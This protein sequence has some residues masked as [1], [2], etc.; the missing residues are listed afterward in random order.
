LEEVEPRLTYFICTLPRSGSWL[1]S[2]ALERTGLAGLPREFF[3]PSRSATWQAS[4]PADYVRRI[5]RTGSTPNGVFGVKFHWYQFQYACGMFQE[6]PLCSGMLPPQAIAS[7]FGEVR[8]IWLTRRDKVRQAISYYR[9]S[10]TDEW[11]IVKGVRGQTRSPRPKPP[12]FDAAA[13]AGLERSVIAHDTEWQKYFE[14]SGIQPLVIYYEEL[15]QDFKAVVRQVLQF[16]GLQAARS[17]RLSTR[18]RRQADSLTEKWRKEYL[19]QRQAAAGSFA[20]LM[21]PVTVALQTGVEHIGG[22]RAP[23]GGDETQSACNAGG[24]GRGSRAGATEPVTVSS[25]IGSFNEREIR[26]AAIQR[27]GHHGIIDWIAAQCPG[28]VYFLNDAVPGSNPFMTCTLVTRLDQPEAKPLPKGLLELYVRRG[29][30]IHNYEDRP[31][32]AVFDEQFE[33]QHDAWVGRSATRYDVIVLRDPFNTFASRLSATWMRHKL[34]DPM[35]RAA[36]IALW[37]SYALEALD[38]TQYAKHRKLFINYNRWFGDREY[39]RELAEK[40]RLTFTDLGRQRVC[41]EY[42]GS[43]FDGL[44]FNG[45]AQEMAVLERWK[46]VAHEPGFR[47][48]FADDELRHLSHELFGDLPGTERLVTPALVA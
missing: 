31:L 3:E 22:P 24:I 44:E 30:L 27:S 16:L 17:L 36:A 14:E 11:W 4:S 2:D 15:A 26:I 28:P 18:M 6:L 48:L 9:A 13:I 47:E 33:R 38:R 46:R 23:A 40:L 45:R 41:G 7:V 19:R 21:S 12:P 42:G 1:L 43:S 39:R 25:E 8:Y 35:G 37:K 20:A 34:H 10:R 32:E 5:V 29:C